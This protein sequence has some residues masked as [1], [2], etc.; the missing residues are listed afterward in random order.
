MNLSVLN[1]K[2]PAFI[3]GYLSRIMEIGDR[4]DSYLR[5]YMAQALRFDANCK[6]G[7]TIQCGNVCRKPE[8]CKQKPQSQAKEPSATTKKSR[9]CTPGKTIECGNVCRKPENCKEPQLQANAKKEA[10]S[11]S[12]KRSAPSKS[13][14]TIDDQLGELRKKYKEKKFTQTLRDVGTEMYLSPKSISVSSKTTD[15]KL[16][17]AFKS[18]QNNWSP[19]FVVEAGEDEY[20]SIGNH[21]DRVINSAA[22]AKTRVFTTILPN[23]ANQIDIAEKMQEYPDNENSSYM[24]K[25]SSGGMRD[26]GQV[27]NIYDADI[28]PPS[29]K[30]KKHNATQQEVDALAKKILETN[31]KNWVPVIVKQTGE[32]KY[33]VVGNHFAYD[34]MKR[35]GTGRMWAT[36]VD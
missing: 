4:S 32:D 6:P 7:K 11:S 22:A 17:S 36:V 31:G 27:M 29:S 2:S 14:T 30:S 21:S 15:S 8:N 26:V 34:V 19:A 20:K 24:K 35:A 5:G 16:T 18:G 23:D 1:G 25:M 10:N 9:N 13:K 12:S 33:E 3:R 28:S